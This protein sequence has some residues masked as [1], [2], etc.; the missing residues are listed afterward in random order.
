M[1]QTVYKFNIT[2]RR[3]LELLIVI[4]VSVRTDYAA[5][6]NPSF[7]LPDLPQGASNIPWFDRVLPT[8]GRAL[9]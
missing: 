3:V 8:L 5:G 2:V 4:V 1:L 9:C 7:G 6:R